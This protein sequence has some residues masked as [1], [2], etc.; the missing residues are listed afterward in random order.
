M[1]SQP[2]RSADS[3]PSCQAAS[4][5]AALLGANLSSMS[6]RPQHED[7]PHR[8]DDYAFRVGVLLASDDRPAGHI[9]ALPLVYWYGVAG[10][11]WWRRWGDPKMT[12]D[13]YTHLARRQPP[14]RD[15]FYWGDNSTS[16]LSASRR[17][18][19]ERRRTPTPS[20]GYLTKRPD[21]LPS[22]CWALTLAR[23]D[24]SG[25]HADGPWG[26]SRLHDGPRR[27]R[28]RYSRRSDHP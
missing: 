14:F 20:H 2:W 13:L 6:W 26:N 22:R 10:H 21:R 7:P 3:R 23:S 12:V 9:L 11:L 19:S 15:A 24:E 25:P 16:C 4:P 5:S 18:R 17:A 8:L 27:H 28:R 1:A